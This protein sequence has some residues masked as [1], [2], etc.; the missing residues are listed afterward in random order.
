MPLEERRASQSREYELIIKLL[1]GHRDS[2]EKIFNKLDGLQCQRMTQ[3]IEHLNSRVLKIEEI[4]EKKTNLFISGGGF[5][6]GAAALLYTVFGG[7]KP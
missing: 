7:N 6:T 3:C 5:I 1:D 4:P 2:L